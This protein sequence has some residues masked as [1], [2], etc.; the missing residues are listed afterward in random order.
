M[1]YP[2]LFGNHFLQKSFG[3]YKSRDFGSFEARMS[4]EEK[5]KELVEQAREP[6]GDLKLSQI[7]KKC[8]VDYDRLWRFMHKDYPDYLQAADA[9][10]IYE[11]LT[12]QPLLPASDEL[13]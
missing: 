6:I 8:K 4:I 10:A 12:G 13:R 11:T 7:A 9:Q 1:P 2:I 5:V 3:L